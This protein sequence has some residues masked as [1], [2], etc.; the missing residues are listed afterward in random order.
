MRLVRRGRRWIFL[1]FAFA[2]VSPACRYSVDPNS[3]KFHCASDADCGSGWFCFDTCQTAGFSAYCLE[4]GSCKACPDLD[5]DP[6]NC[7]TCGKVC[8]AGDGCI[9][10]VCIS[11]FLADAGEPDAGFDAGP[12]DAGLDAGF[13]GGPDGGEDAGRDG[14]E[15]AGRD[16]GTILDGGRADASVDAGRDGGEPDASVDGGIPDGGAQDASSDAGPA[17]A[18][19]AGGLDASVD[20]GEDGGS[21][22]DD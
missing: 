2:T 21:N 13:D 15:D 8:P 7:G 17:D 1:F 14:G 19:D 6:N 16:A 10:G 20:G 9:D 22:A 4:N 12:E 5:D 11:P 18:G 3:G